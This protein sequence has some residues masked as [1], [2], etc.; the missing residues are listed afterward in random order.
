[1]KERSDI[2]LTDA[3]AKAD[4]AAAQVGID[5]NVPKNEPLPQA[6]VPFVQASAL[7]LYQLPRIPLPLLLLDHFREFINHSMESPNFILCYSVW[8]FQNGNGC[9]ILFA[10]CFPL[11]YLLPRDCSRC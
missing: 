5:V 8:R 9:S 4:Q 7:L 11:E 6:F 10:C 1:M 3:V 2:F